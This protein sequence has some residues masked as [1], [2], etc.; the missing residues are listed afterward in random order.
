MAPNKSPNP[1]KQKLKIPTGAISGDFKASDWEI[2]ARS[3]LRGMAQSD[4]SIVCSVP[5]LNHHVLRFRQD[6]VGGRDW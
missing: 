6:L 5:A 4:Q 3:K 2:R 1:K